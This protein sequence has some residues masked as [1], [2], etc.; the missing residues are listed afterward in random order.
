[1]AVYNQTEGNAPIEVRIEP[2]KS[3]NVGFYKNTRADV[4]M[5]CHYIKSGQQEIQNYTDRVC[6]PELDEYI[7]TKAE[8]TIAPLAE[9]AQEAAQSALNSARECAEMVAGLTMEEIVAV[10]ANLRSEADAALQE[11]LDDACLEL[12][13]KAAG[14][15]VYDKSETDAFLSAKAD[16]NSPAFSG[17]PTAPTADGENGLQIANVAA[18][19]GVVD[20]I[21]SANGLYSRITTGNGQWCREWFSDQDMM[22]RVWLEQ[23]GCFSLSQTGVVEN[24]VTFLKAFGNTN[25]HVV[26]SMEHSYGGTISTCRAWVGL[27]SKTT[28]GVKFFVDHSNGVSCSWHACGI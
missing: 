25:Y 12:A 17:T 22:Q 20:G 9:T 15:D 26:R 10:E 3:L 11:A 6:K 13:A 18:V 8:Q 23:G 7:L 21:M 2:E 4:A 27:S 19:N 24:S 16:V 14:A 28:T 1:M 5:S